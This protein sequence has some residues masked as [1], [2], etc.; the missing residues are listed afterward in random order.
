MPLLEK[1]LILPQTHENKMTQKYPDIMS[2]KDSGDRV[3]FIHI[4]STETFYFSE[5]N[6]NDKYS[7][8]FE[9]CLCLIV[10]G[11]EKTTGNYISFLGHLSPNMSLEQHVPFFLITFREKLEVFLGQ[12]HSETVIATIGGS[13]AHK[14]GYRKI[15][16][17]NIAAISSVL[18]MLSVQI[19][20]QIFA[21]K[22]TLD[23]VNNFYLKNDTGI[24]YDRRLYKTENLRANIMNQVVKESFLS[25]NMLGF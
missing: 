16:K 23:I 14:R 15:Y 20:L 12:C 6:S 5:I 1:I 9:G 4:F 17:M 21:P 24:L 8:F 13:C 22:R 25:M 2:I 7:D 3:P 19:R 18:S 10:R 11:I